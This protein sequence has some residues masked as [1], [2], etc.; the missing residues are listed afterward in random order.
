MWHAGCT[1]TVNED[2]AVGGG[3]MPEATMA[4][5]A[6]SRGTTAAGTN[7]SEGFTPGAGI[8]TPSA[9]IS[10][11]G[12]GSSTPGAGTTSSSARGVPVGE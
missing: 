2:G 6:S 5:S 9:G 3:G 10:T 1:G 11:P 7:V 4:S 12:A 8:S